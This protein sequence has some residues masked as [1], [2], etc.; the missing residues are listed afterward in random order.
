MPN[1]H[2][3]GLHINAGLRVNLKHAEFGCKGWEPKKERD[4]NTESFH[5]SYPAVLYLVT[6]IEVDYFEPVMKISILLGIVIFFE[7][8]ESILKSSLVKILIV[9][10]VPDEVGDGGSTMGSGIRE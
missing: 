3:G 9:F 6:E 8:G 2:K 7:V 5:I 10:P 1:L 4:T